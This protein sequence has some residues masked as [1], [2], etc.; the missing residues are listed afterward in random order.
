MGD[1]NVRDVRGKIAD[2]AEALA[3]I[4]HPDSTE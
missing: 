3:L 4:D 2:D 1:V